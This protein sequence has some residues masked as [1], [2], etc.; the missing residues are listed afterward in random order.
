M[1]GLHKK[2]VVCVKLMIIVSKNNRAK[3]FNFFFENVGFGG[4]PTRNLEESGS[5]K[6]LCAK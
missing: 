2:S 6:G 4:S 5:F 3:F 1:S